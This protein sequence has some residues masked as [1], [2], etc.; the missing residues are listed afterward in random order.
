[1][2]IEINEDTP[3]LADITATG[4]HRRYRLIVEQNS[5][6]SVY[7]EAE[8]HFGQPYWELLLPGLDH[9][10]IVATVIVALARQ[11]VGGNE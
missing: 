11:G 8:D 7:G 10:A 4:D 1:M 3:F 6:P 2:T 5:S 9:A